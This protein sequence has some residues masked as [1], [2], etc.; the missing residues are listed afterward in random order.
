MN[1]TACRF[2][3]SYTRP[4]GQSAWESPTSDAGLLRVPLTTPYLYERPSETYGVLIE[5]RWGDL[6]TH[7]TSVQLAAPLAETAPQPATQPSQGKLGTP[8][9]RVKARLRMLRALPANHDRQGAMAPNTKSIDTAIAFIDL[10]ANTPSFTATLDDDGSAVL[11]FENRAAEFFA[12]ITFRSDGRIEFY[13][14]EGGRESEY[15]EDIKIED[16]RKFLEPQV[17]LA[18]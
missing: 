11:E 7:W 3:E 13:K 1:A 5:H 15:F 16:A 17:E 10:T 18:A 12:D 4:A 14:R 9:D 6:A 2:E 8:S